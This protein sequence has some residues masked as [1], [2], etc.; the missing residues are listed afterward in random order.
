MAYTPIVIGS[1]NWGAP[2]NAAFTSQD[3]RISDIEAQGSLTLG[4]TTL[5]ATNYD[6][7]YGAAAT[8]LTS[9][10]VFM[11]RIDVPYSLLVSN[12][13]QT[14]VTTAGSGLVAAQNFAGLYTAAGT[15]IG[16]TA[17]QSVA[18]TTTGEKNMAL[19][20][21]A[22]I[23]AGTYYVALL[24]NGTTPPSFLRIAVSASVSDLVNHGLTT[25]TARWTTGPTAQTTLP[26]SITMASRVLS[27]TT[28][29][30]GVS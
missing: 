9:G 29:F 5:T 21:P 30:A 19:V 4:A 13:H 12:I 20:A 15:R 25:S 22:L 11:Q 1:L 14:I 18:W 2:V 8:A 7:A 17:D 16:V 24:S 27:G 3:L 6:P 26:A 28:Y 23:T 10:T